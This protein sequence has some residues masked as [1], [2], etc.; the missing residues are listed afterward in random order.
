MQPVIVFSFS[1]RECEAY[2]MSVAKLDFN[3][4]EEKEAVEEVGLFF[5]FPFNLFHVNNS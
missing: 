1:R 4:D 2:A 3:S 5:F